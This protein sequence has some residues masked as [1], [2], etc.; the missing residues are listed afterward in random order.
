VNR[1]PEPI[2]W[3]TDNGSCATARN[4]RAFSR[5]IGLVPLTTPISS[6]Q[7]NGMAEVFVRPPPV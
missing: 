1:V 5:G 6:P 7:S 2:E 3:P 4:T